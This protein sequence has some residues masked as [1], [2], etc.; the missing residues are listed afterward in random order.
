MY[1]N[2]LSSYDINYTIVRIREKRVAKH[3][4]ITQRTARCQKLYYNRI[5]LKP[6]Q[7]HQLTN[8]VITYTI[9]FQV[10][11]INN[12]LLSYKHGTKL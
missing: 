1:V 8:N 10:K 5:S 6:T 9:D 3:I 2:M 11:L 4:V 7:L 12:Q